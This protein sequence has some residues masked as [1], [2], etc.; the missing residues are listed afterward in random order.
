MLRDSNNGKKKHSR[1]GN[2]DDSDF[3]S[4]NQYS[5]LLPLKAI[6]PK[7][8]NE[9]LTPWQVQNQTKTWLTLTLI[10]APSQRLHPEYVALLRLHRLSEVSSYP[11]HSHAATLHGC[12]LSNSKENNPLVSRNSSCH[13][14]FTA[15]PDLPMVLSPNAFLEHT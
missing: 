14:L 7:E 4:N 1:G 12:I 2:S 8:W 15:R 11:F 5:S 9:L 3:I 13:L 10:R 6:H